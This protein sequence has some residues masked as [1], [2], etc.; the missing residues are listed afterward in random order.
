MT[1]EQPTPLVAR[2][3]IICFIRYLQPGVETNHVYRRGDIL[4]IQPV[5]HSPQAG[6]ELNNTLHAISLT[7]SDIQVQLCSIKNQI[8]E[9]DASRKKH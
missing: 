8:V 7:L 3:I 9:R 6:S 5:P 1:G 4:P 2:T